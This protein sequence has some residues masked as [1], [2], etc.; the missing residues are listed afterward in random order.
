MNLIIANLLGIAMGALLAAVVYCK[1]WWKTHT[2]E[3]RWRISLNHANALAK[4]V[5]RFDP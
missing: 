3:E 5:E 2:T 4:A 1:H